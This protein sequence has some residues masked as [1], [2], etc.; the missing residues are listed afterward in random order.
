[1]HL[2]RFELKVSF[3]LKRFAVFY[4][5]STLSKREDSM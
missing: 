4:Q 2:F 5:Q 3:A 1:M